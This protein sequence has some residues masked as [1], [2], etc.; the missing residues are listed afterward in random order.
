M[1][2]MRPD[3][4]HSELTDA[5]IGV[6]FDVYNELGHGFLESVCEASMAIGLKDAGLRVER[7]VPIAVWFRGQQ[8]GTFIAD[9]V[10]EGLVI[11]ELKAARNIDPGHEAQLLNYLRATQIEVGLLMN[12]GIKAEFKRLVFDNTRKTGQPPTT[13]S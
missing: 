6:F 5:I 12:F 4:K 8:V 10:V 1:H 2:A 13:L 7:Q 3:A 9:L 11:V